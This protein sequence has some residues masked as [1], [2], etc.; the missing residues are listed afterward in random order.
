MQLGNKAQHT[1]LYS[2]IKVHLTIKDSKT[3]LVHHKRFYEIENISDEPIKDVLHGIS[4]DIEKY[5]ITDL[6]VNTYDEDGREMKI[7]SIS[8]DKPDI[9]EFTTRFVEPIV[10][11]EKARGYTMEYETEEPDRYYK[12][13]FLIDCGKFE[14]GFIYPKNNSV[15]EP[16][17]YDVN[18]ET[19]KKTKS[20]L[21]PTITQKIMIILQ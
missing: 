12:N 8:M 7:S 10:K 4:T 9:K 13:A 21:K 19:D 5:S 2:Q 1:T 18:Q 15:Q 6:K 17:L 11:G 14:L 20:N 3:M 16:V